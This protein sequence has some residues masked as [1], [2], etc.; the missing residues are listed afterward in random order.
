LLPNGRKAISRKNPT[1]N[2]DLPE[3]GK[4]KKNE[5]AVQVIFA[6]RG[7]EA[8][9]PAELE[10]LLTRWVSGGKEAHRSYEKF[11]DLIPKY[12][13]EEYEKPVV[14]MSDEKAQELIERL[15]EIDG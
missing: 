8:P 2:Y 12:K 5:E 13:P 3:R 10:V 4:V 11:L 9:Y 14:V 15:I 1:E 7:F 6:E